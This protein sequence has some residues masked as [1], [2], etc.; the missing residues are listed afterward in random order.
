ML[1]AAAHE[2]ENG[3]TQTWRNVRVESEMRVIT[4]AVI[5]RFNRL[6]FLGSYYQDGAPI[7]APSDNSP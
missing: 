7:A 4:D 6:H 3:P 2:S 5:T 1:F